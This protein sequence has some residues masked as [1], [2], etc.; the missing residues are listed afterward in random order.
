[1]KHLAG[2]ELVSQRIARAVHRAEK[3]KQ[4]PSTARRKELAKRHWYAKLANPQ[5]AAIDEDDSRGDLFDSLRADDFNN[6]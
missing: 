6:P 4:A 3:V 5:P 2:K 1:M